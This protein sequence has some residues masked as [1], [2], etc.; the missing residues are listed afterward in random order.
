MAKEAKAKSAKATPQKKYD[1]TRGVPYLLYLTAREKE[2]F[3]IRADK[4]GESLAVWMRRHL[5]QAAIAE[6]G[7][8]NLFE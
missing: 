5:R 1:R 4:R 7:N 2:E 3:L 6:S 8:E